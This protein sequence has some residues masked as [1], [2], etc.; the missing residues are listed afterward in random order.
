MSRSKHSTD[1]YIC[2]VCFK[3]QRRIVFMCH[4][5]HR[6]AT[7]DRF[8]GEKSKGASGAWTPSF[9][10]MCWVINQPFQVPWVWNAGKTLN[11]HTHFFSKH[12]K[13]S[14]SMK[15]LFPPSPFP[16]IKECT[17][18]EHTKINQSGSQTWNTSH[19]HGTKIESFHLS[20]SDTTTQHR[21]LQ[22][23]AAIGFKCSL[24]CELG[25]PSL[26][27]ERL[28]EVGLTMTKNIRVEQASPVAIQ[29]RKVPGQA[30]VEAIASLPLHNF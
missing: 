13:F 8:A 20:L 26:L 10:F 21:K 3:W 19:I 5:V 12:S 4:R 15:L 29:K 24:K 18:K 22:L 6:F 1:S 7:C 14:I 23:E 28:K 27:C 9:S 11:T 30:V 17:E 2:S 16:K 25:F